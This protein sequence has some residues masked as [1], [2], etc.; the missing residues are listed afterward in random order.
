MNQWSRVLAFSNSRL[1]RPVGVEEEMPDAAAAA[2]WLAA[3]FGVAPKVG[4]SRAAVPLEDADFRAALLLRS[5]VRSLIQARSAGNGPRPQDLEVLNRSSARAC[6]YDL[7][8]SGWDRDTRYAGAAGLAGRSPRVQLASLASDAI[9]LLSAPTVDVTEC[10]ADDC[11]VLFER[12]DPR[13]RWHS[14]RCGNRVRA[15]RSYARRHGE[16]G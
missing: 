7:L 8:T 9:A 13:R 2:R 5:A 4:P 11:V 10:A 1:D 12:T 15:A 14:D 3:C 6:R 16:P